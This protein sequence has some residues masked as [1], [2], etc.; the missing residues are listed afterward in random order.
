MNIHYEGNNSLEF[1][2]NQ[3]HALETLI[4]QCIKVKLRIPNELF[5][6]TFDQFIAKIN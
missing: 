2:R 1:Y 5:D 6:S 4:E 3:S